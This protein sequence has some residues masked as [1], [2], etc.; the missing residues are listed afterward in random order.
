M[1]TPSLTIKD[2]TTFILIN[3]NS[4]VFIGWT[5]SEISFALANAF[6]NFCC[7]YAIDTLT[8]EVVGVCLVERNDTY[9]VITCLEILVKK[10]CRGVV[11]SFIKYFSILYPPSNGWSLQMCRRDNLKRIFDTKRFCSLTLK[12][13]V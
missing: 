2:L 5:E 4:K 13:K 6:K 9:K 8:G 3:R 12:L 11:S 7:N 1:S 10:G